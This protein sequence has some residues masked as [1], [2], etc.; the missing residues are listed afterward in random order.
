MARH[1]R[2]KGLHCLFIAL[3]DIV[4]RVSRHAI[5]PARHGLQDP[6]S[7]GA[8]CHSA[9]LVCSCVCDI[10]KLVCHETAG[11]I[12]DVPRNSVV[13]LRHFTAV[14]MTIGQEMAFCAS[15]NSLG[16]NR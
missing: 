16:V 12:V 8:C 2:V 15:D 9:Q 7:N 1:R 5:D 14:A 10:H 4:L 11:Y 6:L 3:C 13:Q